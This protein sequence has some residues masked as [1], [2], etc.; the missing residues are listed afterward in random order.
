MT[1]PQSAERRMRALELVWVNPVCPK[2]LGRPSRIVTIDA[3]TN[4]ELAE[5]MPASGCPTCGEPVFREYHHILEERGG[6]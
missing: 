4:E 3:D 2:C 6:A 1:P 5:N